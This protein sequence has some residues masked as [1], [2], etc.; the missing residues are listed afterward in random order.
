MSSPSTPDESSASSSFGHGLDS[1]GM[2]TSDSD[3]SIEVR[4]NEAKVQ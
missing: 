2:A 3:S 1:A 4:I